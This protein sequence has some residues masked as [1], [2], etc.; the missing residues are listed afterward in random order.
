M[1]FYLKRGAKCPV[2]VSGQE[3]DAVKIAAE[4]LRTDLEKVFGKVEENAEANA[5]GSP[6]YTPGAYSAPEILAGTLGVSPDFD[7]LVKTDRL[8]D[9][10]LYEESGKLRREGYLMYVQELSLIHI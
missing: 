6:D 5:C 8:S 1:S 9:C 7:A 10:G 2:R 4:N 3:T